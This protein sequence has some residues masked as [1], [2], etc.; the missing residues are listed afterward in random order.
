MTVMRWVD[1]RVSNRK[2]Y[3]DLVSPKQVVASRGM[4]PE[5]PM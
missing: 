5:L 3:L 4:L 1:M 2:G